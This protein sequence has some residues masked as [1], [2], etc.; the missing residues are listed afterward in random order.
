VPL[1]I[2][3]NNMLGRLD[4]PESRLIST[5]E[6]YSKIRKL[7]IQLFFDGAREHGKQ[8]ISHDRLKISYSGHYHSADQKILEFIAQ[9]KDKHSW[10]LITDDNHLAQEAKYQGIKRQKINQL[11][12]QLAAN[13][14]TSPQRDEKPAFEPDPDNLLRQMLDKSNN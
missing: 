1:I 4:W 7:K 6:S 10:Y 8:H 13:K 9:L 14:N 11:F 3:G 2:D 12:G 5:L